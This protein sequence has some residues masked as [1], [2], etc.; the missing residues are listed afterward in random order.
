M[1]LNGRQ[2]AFYAAVHKARVRAFIVKRLAYFIVG[3]IMRLVRWSVVMPP[4]EPL[5]IIELRGADKKLSAIGFAA[6]KRL[7]ENALEGENPPAEIRIYED[8]GGNVPYLA[9][10]LRPSFPAPPASLRSAD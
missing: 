10:T 1:Q 8:H 6:A 5:Y 2:S 7:A 3:E 4:N 9:A